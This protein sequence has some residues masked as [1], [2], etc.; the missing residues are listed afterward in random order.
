MWI[1]VSF[2]Q[3]DAV[4]AVPAHWYKKGLCAWPKKDTKKHIERRTIANKFDFNYF[5]SRILKKD[6]GKYL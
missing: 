2:D 6:I 1:V 5:P 4:E 3:E